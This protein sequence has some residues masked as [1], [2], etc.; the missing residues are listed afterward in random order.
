MLQ[1][2]LK[3]SFYG[4]G[5]EDLYSSLNF[6]L[7]EVRY[8][9]MKVLAAQHLRQRAHRVYRKLLVFMVSRGLVPRGDNSGVVEL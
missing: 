7:Y 8:T 3:A 2:E 5:E 6:K 1:T 9:L 4:D